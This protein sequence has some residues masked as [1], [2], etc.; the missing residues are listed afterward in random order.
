MKTTKLEKTLV[1]TL[2][3]MLFQNLR[4]SHLIEKKLEKITPTFQNFF[5]IIYFLIFI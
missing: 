2:L 1:Q 5:K 3:K 4:V